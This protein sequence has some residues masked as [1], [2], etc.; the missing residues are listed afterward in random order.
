MV[1]HTSSKLVNTGGL[2][3]KDLLYLKEVQVTRIREVLNGGLDV[4]TLV[5]NSKAC[6]TFQHI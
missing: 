2:M 5:K 6:T 1:E 3:T 4:K